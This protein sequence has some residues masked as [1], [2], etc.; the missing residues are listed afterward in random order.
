MVT[1]LSTGLHSFWSF[2]VHLLLRAGHWGVAV[3]PES[4]PSWSPRHREKNT[5]KQII[6][7]QIV[8]SAIEKAL[9]ERE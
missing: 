3:N 2:A 7:I 4:L 8:S 9:S 6:Q 5:H 1:V